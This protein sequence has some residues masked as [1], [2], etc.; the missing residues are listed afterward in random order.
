MVLYFDIINEQGL[1]AAYASA[2]P[3]VSSYVIIRPGGLLDSV[4]VGPGI[5]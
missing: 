2:D 3:S 1:K 4:A 5:L